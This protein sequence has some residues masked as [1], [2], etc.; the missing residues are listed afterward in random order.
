[1]NGDYDMRQCKFYHFLLAISLSV[2]LGAPSSAQEGLGGMPGAYMYMGVGARALGLGG[3]YTAIANDATAVYWNP[4]GLAD[5]NPFRVSFMHAV[6]FMD[7]SLDFFAASAPTER[8]GSFGAALMALNSGGFEQRTA[9][10]EVVGNFNTRDV[11]IMASWSKQFMGNLSLGLSYKF[12]TQKILNYSGSG[13][14]LDVGLKTLLFDRLSAGL[15]FRNLIQPNVILATDDQNYPMQMGIGASTFIINDQVLVSAEVSKISGWGE[16]VYHFGAEYRVMN[17]AAIRIG[18][19]KNSFTF[20]AGFNFNALDFGYSNVGGSDLGSSHRFSI[21]YAFGGFGVDAD[22]YPRIFSPAGEQSVTRIRL[23]AKSRDQIENWMFVIL[24]AKGKSIRQ[25]TQSGQPPK[26]IVWD[27]R[28]GMGSLVKDG[29][30][31]YVFNIK[32]VEG[33]VM[34][35][36]GK[37][38]TID[39]SGPQ[40]VFAS[41]EEE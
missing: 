37:L 9:L 11:S 26:E 28:D 2:C 40:G 6:L 16:M 3:A 12:V 31:K 15:V 30:F 18:A 20:G 23:K 4:A 34:N 39:S 41:S 14:G 22:A 17:Q 1:M 21:D 35:S 36:E 25:F 7:T 32:T 38:V 27:G 29:Q 10:N 24:D 19:N 8:Y 33:R 13:H 5:Q